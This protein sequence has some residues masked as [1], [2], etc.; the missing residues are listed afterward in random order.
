M[1]NL[2]K[3]KSFDEKTMISFINYIIDEGDH[4][5]ADDLYEVYAW[6]DN[7]S[8]E[9]EVKEWLRIDSLEK[10]GW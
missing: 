8:N 2:E 7:G 6:P 5:L 9:N 1:N 4:A 10:K 3:I